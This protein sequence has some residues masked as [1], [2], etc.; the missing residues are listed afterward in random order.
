MRKCQFL[1]ERPFT[2]CSGRAPLVEVDRFL[3]C[4]AI[5]L[6][7]SL[8]LEL[9]MLQLGQWFARKNKPKGLNKLDWGYP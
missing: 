6:S 2:E 3:T 4:G 8:S 1:N 7:G 5:F 9:S